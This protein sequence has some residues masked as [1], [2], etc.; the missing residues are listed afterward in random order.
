M[1]T[2][3]RHANI[4]VP[5]RASSQLF[6]YQGSC[7]LLYGRGVTSF[8]AFWCGD[9]CSRWPEASNGV[10]ISPRNIKDELKSA[11]SAQWSEKRAV[12]KSRYPALLREGSKPDKMNI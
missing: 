2:H 3:E 10:P 1:H 4:S 7:I 12:W 11:Q 6:A 9:E 8:G 5:Q